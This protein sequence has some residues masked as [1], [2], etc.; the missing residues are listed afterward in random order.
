MVHASL[1]VKSMLRKIRV[2]VKGFGPLRDSV[3]CRVVEVEE[4]ATLEKVLE[5][6]VY[7]IDQYSFNDEVA[8]DIEGFKRKEIV[9]LLNGRNIQFL[10]GLNVKV[11]DGDKIALL[12]PSVGG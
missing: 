5:K 9:I 3:G 2:I 12:V 4:G 7:L 10:G 8:V 1:G 11:R 6:L